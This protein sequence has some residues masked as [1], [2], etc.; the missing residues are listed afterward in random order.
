MS[1][2]S[3]SLNCNVNVSSSLGRIAWNCP[4]ASNA[5]HIMIV[6]A[7]KNDGAVEQASDTQAILL[8]VGD[9]SN[10]IPLPS[11]LAQMLG[12]VSLS[13]DSMD[14]DESPF[15]LFPGHLPAEGTCPSTEFFHAALWVVGS[16][17]QRPDEDGEGGLV[18]K[19]VD[20]FPSTD[21]MDLG[22][23]RRN[24]VLYMDPAPTDVYYPKK[25]AH[26]RIL[27]MSEEG[28]GKRPRAGSGQAGEQTILS[29]GGTV[30]SK[31]SV[32]TL[33]D[34]DNQPCSCSNKSETHGRIIKCQ[35]LLRVLTENSNERELLLPDLL[36][37]T[38]DYVARI[39]SLHSR[40]GTSQLGNFGFLKF[41]PV[42]ADSAQLQ[43]AILGEWKANNWSHLSV[44]SFISQDTTHMN[45]TIWCQETGATTTGLQLLSNGLSGLQ[46]F[47]GMF[48]HR[49]FNNCLEPLIAQV[50]RQ[51]EPHI[52]S[53]HNAFLRA[54]VEELIVD[55]CTDVRRMR[56][57]DRFD[58]V[59]LKTRAGCLALLQAYISAFI[60][61][62]SP[63]DL[64]AGFWEP[65]PHHNFY[66]NGYPDIIQDK[67]VSSSASGKVSTSTVSSKGVSSTPTK[68]SVPA[69]TTEACGL[70][71]AASFG[72]RH[73]T[74]QL[75]TCRKHTKCTYPHK[76]LKQLSRVEANI[77]ANNVP[78]SLKDGLV[79]ALGPPDIRR[80]RRKCAKYAEGTLNEDRLAA[81]I[82]VDT[83][84][85]LLIPPVSGDL[86]CCPRDTFGRLHIVIRPSI[87]AGAQLGAFPRYPVPS[88]TRIGA[89]FGHMASPRDETRASCVYRMSWDGIYVDARDLSGIIC[90]CAY[91]N[92]P[93]DALQENVRIERHGDTLWVV[94]TQA[95]QV[96]QK[97]GFGYGAWYWFRQ[98]LKL[99]LALLR[100]VHQRYY[101][102]SD[103]RMWCAIMD[104]R[105]FEPGGMYN[106]FPPVIDQRPAG[107]LSNL[108]TINE[109]QS[110]NRS[111]SLSGDHN[112]HQIECQIHNEHQ[113]G[114]RSESLSGDHNEHQIECQIHNE[115]QGG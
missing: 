59:D 47:W 90:R 49:D 52:F 69:K 107:S 72:H 104:C 115:H 23:F 97:F 105:K 81:G 42:M 88:G 45:S 41:M 114:Q 96:G 28:A 66:T 77:A 20:T 36:F 43:C 110:E 57:S 27:Q 46:L 60:T 8:F 91:I 67:P 103:N 64:A 61:R 34:L 53:C 92:D 39:K 98:A 93:L 109:H 6:D 31:Y 51:N 32:G 16:V 25:T 30:T 14:P 83:W 85:E 68:S 75:V 73:T 29:V 18:V 65:A 11:G 111:E 100:K 54:R 9:R 21:G 99:P 48:W 26:K 80:A 87:H 101:V 13:D 17:L 40:P 108:G 38:T 37:T 70:F 71:M 62:P 19:I 55:F 89:Y 15:I 84:Q 7:F 12:L 82:P 1:S 95:V 112:E 56:R 3:L 4:I 50:G 86:E 22:S 44:M 58:Q 74:Q 94:T 76:P 35:L 2:S 102:A 106:P 78:R 63:E 5:P 113:G 24:S 33:P 10:H 79:L